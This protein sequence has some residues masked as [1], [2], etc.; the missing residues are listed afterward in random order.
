M[1]GQER[2]D[3]LSLQPILLHSEKWPD[4]PGAKGEIQRLKKKTGCG[5]ND[6]LVVVW[7]IE[8]DT[9]CAAEEVRLRYADA[10]EGI[11]NETRQPFVD[12]STDFERILPG[13][14]RMYPD[15]DS[16]PQQITRERMERLR[17]AL[18]ELP[19]LREE[20]YSGVGVPLDTIY[21]LI[22]RGGARLV[23]LVVDR[24]GADVR[25]ACFFFGERIK[26]L[27]RDGV[28]VDGISDDLWCDLFS[29]VSSD[30]TLFEDWKRIVS[31]MAAVRDRSMRDIVEEI[32]LDKKPVSWREDLLE[33]VQTKQP[34]YP[35]DS[36][37]QRHRFLMGTVMKNLRGRITAKDVSSALHSAMEDGA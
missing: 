2:L 28:A 31:Q 8:Q 32:G 21:F 10:V 18:P 27:R 7:G 26:G 33:A 15:T 14:D 5:A 20:R 22:R 23:D 16:P 25:R 9:L 37:G 36:V 1:I 24:G 12:G 17:D 30:G 19:W 29:L 34:D 11:P 3:F 13:P 4:Y 35:N 6:S